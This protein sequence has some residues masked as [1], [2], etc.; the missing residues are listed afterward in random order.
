MPQIYYMRPTALLPLRRKACWG[1]FSA[2]ILVIFITAESDMHLVLFC[3]VSNKWPPQTPPPRY[4]TA[5]KQL[6]WKLLHR[7]CSWAGYAPMVIQNLPPDSLIFDILNLLQTSTFAK[8]AKGCTSDWPTADRHSHGTQTHCSAR[9]SQGS[10]APHTTPATTKNMS[11]VRQ[12][13][14]VSAPT[15][16][17]F[18][19]TSYTYFCTAAGC[20]NLCLHHALFR[21]SQRQNK[22]DILDYKF[23]DQIII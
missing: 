17:T 20:N 11:A 3:T 9:I 2:Y 12:F 18:F 16:M 22:H 5:Y 7:L 8:V 15:D 10:E 14:R 4:A 21:Y 6:R 19:L 23:W 1:F 13:S